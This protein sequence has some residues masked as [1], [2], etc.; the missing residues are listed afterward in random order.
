[1]DKTE[2]RSILSE[3]LARYRAR[4]YAELAA[5]VKEHRIDEAEIV[6]PGGTPYHIEVNFLWDNRRNGNVRVI[7][8]IDDGSM[9][10]FIFPLSDSFILSPEGRFIGE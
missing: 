6:A 10:T 1:M 7:G 4:P 8:A 9:R 2:A 3:Y 5:W